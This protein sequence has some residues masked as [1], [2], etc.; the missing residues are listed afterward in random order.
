MNAWVISVA[1]IL[2]QPGEYK[3]ASRSAPV[4][5]LETTLARVRESS[6]R[7]NFRLQAVVEG[8]LVTGTVRGE[9]ELQCARCLRAS[10]DELSLEVSELFFAPGAGAPDDAYVITGTQVHLEPMV[11]DAVALALPLRPLCRADCKGLCATCGRDL[12]EGPCG[13]AQEETDPRWAPLRALS[14]KLSG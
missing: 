2:G 12:N 7:A 1:D 14:D 13:C 8:V 4:E 5:G 9:A 10:S 6:L 3:D 11:R